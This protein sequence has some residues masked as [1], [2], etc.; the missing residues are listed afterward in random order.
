MPGDRIDGAYDK[1][2]A[3]MSDPDFPLTMLPPYAGSTD[4]EFRSF[5]RLLGERLP[6]WIPA[7]GRDSV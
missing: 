6:E 2:F 1:L 4:E 7:P 5:V 3:K